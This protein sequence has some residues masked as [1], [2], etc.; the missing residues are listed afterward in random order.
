MIIAAHEKRIDA[1]FIFS[2]RHISENLDVAFRFIDKM[3]SYNVVVY[4]I[5]GNTYSYDWFCK[6]IGK[7]FKA[8]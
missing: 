1:L 6:Q 2:I 5:E 4:D 8:D 3:N 7:R